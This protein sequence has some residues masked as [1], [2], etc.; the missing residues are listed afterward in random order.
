MSRLEITNR[1]KVFWPDEG[2]TKG[3][4]VDYYDAISQTIL[5]YLKG[6]PE[7]MNRFPNGINGPSF[8]H[9]DLESHPDWIRTEAIFSES[10]DKDMH[11]L[12]ADDRDS[13]LYM[14]NLGCIEL[15]PWHSRVGSLENPDYCLIDLDAKTN[16]FK[17]IITVA[18]E[19]HKFLDEL[20]IPNYPKTSGKTG[21]HVCIPLGAKYNYDQSR[22]FAQLLVNHIQQRIPTLTSV[23]RSPDK[24]HGQIYLD[25]LQ[26][27]HGQTMAAP[28]CVRPVVAATVSTPLDWSEVKSGLDPKKFTIKTTAKRLNSVGDLWKPVIGKGI[29]MKAVLKKLEP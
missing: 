21:L 26:N 27:R 25:Y 4:L 10:T 8:F 6:R 7:S 24:R 1:D 17:D 5:P 23:D 9:K 14:I 11:W 19:T 15:N 3:D 16:D 20:K 12:I 13:L 2:Y 29:D 18:S 28:Y 22:Q